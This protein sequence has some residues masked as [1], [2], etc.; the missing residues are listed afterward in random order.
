MHVILQLLIKLDDNRL[1]ETVGIPAE[2]KKGSKRLTACVS[3]QVF[4]L[5]YD[6]SIS[7]YSKEYAVD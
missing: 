4:F 7:F 3:S 2:D 5:Y 6:Q 1:I